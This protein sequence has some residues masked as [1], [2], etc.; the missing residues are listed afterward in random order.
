M[1]TAGPFTQADGPQTINLGAETHLPWREIAITITDAGGTPTPPAV[2]V[3]MAGTATG[4]GA[5]VE[6]EFT[7]LLDIGAGERR[8]KPF[9]SFIK[10]IEISPSDLDANLQY[11]VTIV[12]SKG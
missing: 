10:E 4:V 3:K 2:A 12:S 9:F 8:W 5:D 6:E 7:D 11:T 1:I